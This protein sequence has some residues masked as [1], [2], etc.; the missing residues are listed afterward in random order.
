MVGPFPKALAGKNYLV[1]A[2]DHF[3][4]CIEVKTLA[5]IIAKKFKDLFYEDVICRFGIQK[6]LIL[7]NGKQ[8]D[9]KEF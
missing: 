6:I 5:S 9:S 7:E 2:S 4:R 8:F 1:V 3:T